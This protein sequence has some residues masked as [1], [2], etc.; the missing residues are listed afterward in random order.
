M[1]DAATTSADG[2]D[3]ELASALGEETAATWRLDRG[4]QPV[5]VRT[6]R[7]DGRIVAALLE[8]RRPATAAAKIAATWHAAGEEEALIGLVEESVAAATA[9][10]DA[11]VKWQAPPAT[12]LPGRLGFARMRD[13]YVSAPGTTGV[14]GWIRWLRVIPHGEPRY[15]A[16]TSTFTCGAVTALLA[17]ES[18]GAP[19]FAGD[20]GDRD[21]E[22]AFWRSASNFPA[23][24][25][26]GLG[27]ALRESLD[28]ASAG[29]AV[30]VLLD[31][32]GPALLEQYADGGFDRAFRE[33]LQAASL[34]RAEELGIPVRRERV[35]VEELAV[36]LAAGERAL[37]LIDCVAMYGFPAPHWVLAHAARDGV[38]L[39]E[40]PW[41]SA[42]W[43]E[44]WVDTH[45]LPVTL[46]DLDGMAAWGPDGYRGVVLVRPA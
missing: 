10:G 25:P 37:V 32:D 3:L 43:G 33:E 16:Q 1:T 28:A 24:E 12:E 11:A 9:R 20:P 41:I 8:S 30:D 21:R 17:T 23:C 13:P 36:R 29:A 4:P 7:A 18:L 34:R 26:V 42:A 35:T 44:T 27:V 14:A 19:G 15:Y 40:D 38:V 6:A 22:L 39:L 45:E 5:A 2:I 31:T 46:D